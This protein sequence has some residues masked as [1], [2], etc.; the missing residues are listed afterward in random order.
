MRASISDLNG[1]EK[2]VLELLALKPVSY[3]PP[4]HRS[5]VGRLSAQGLLQRDGVCWYPTAFGL[6]CIGRTLH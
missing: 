4:L 1:N 2:V 5:T 3:F 6:V